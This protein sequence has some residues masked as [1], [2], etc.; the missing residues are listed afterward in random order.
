M[1]EEFDPS[2]ELLKEEYLKACCKPAFRVRWIKNKGA[3]LII[4]WS[5]LV[6]SVFHLLK[7][8]YQEKQFENQH[9]VSATGI[10]LSCMFLLFPIGGWLADTRLGRYSV[11]RYS[12]WLMW[13]GVMLATF[14]ELLAYVSITYNVH[15][16]E[17]VFLVLCVIMAIGLG[18]FQSNI[19]QLGIDQ[20]TNASATER[21]SF[22]TWY[23]LTFYASGVIVHYIP[24]CI[25]SE[26]KMLYVKVLL[27]AM[28]LS[29]AICSDFLFQHWII[30]EQVACRDTMKLIWQVVKYTVKH[31][32]VRYSEQLSKFDIAKCEYGGPFMAHQVEN[33]RTFLWMLV[34][35][36]TFSVVYGAMAAVNYANQKVE[37]HFHKWQDS[38]GLIGCYEKLNIRYSHFISTVAFIFLYEFAIHPLLHRCL[39]KLSITSKFVIATVLFMAWIISMLAIEIVTYH[40]KLKHGNNTAKC[41]FTERHEIY[42]MSYKWLLFSNIM[43][44]LSHFLLISSG[45]EFIWAY[46]PLT[47]KGLLLG[48]A[49]MFFGLNTLLHTAIAWPF[50][51]KKPAFIQWS[52]HAPLTCGIWYFLIEGVIMFVLIVI[53]V[54]AIKRYKRRNQ[55]IVPRDLY[56]SSMINVY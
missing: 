49:Y 18:G 14:G 4:I 32:S 16:K 39:P 54:L 7:S 52:K 47:M 13:I 35:V 34:V 22:I 50:L 10:L 55:T 25:V 24:D 26:Y 28:F 53:S 23:T 48:L 30:K 5:Y 36:A 45:L 44:G 1:S 11:I 21:T 37:V 51:F 31:K 29:L 9:H 2:T 33:V 12:M 41:T 20:L 40:D 46:A 42:T 56:A 43:R 17:R 19:V 6:I 3:I 38:S 15:I 27:V 8:G